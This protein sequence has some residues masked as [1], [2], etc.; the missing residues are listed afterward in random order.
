MVYPGSPA[1]AAGLKP[2]DLIVALKV[3]GEMQSVDELGGFT[4]SV[5]H[6]RG[7]AGT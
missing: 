6:L 5:N 4:V 3:D 2:G 7:V 1:E